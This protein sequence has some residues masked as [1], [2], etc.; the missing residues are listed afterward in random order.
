M[1]LFP[2]FKINKLTNKNS[3]D[4]IYVFYGDNLV[5]DEADI[6]F[7][8][9]PD[10]VIFKSIFDDKELDIIKKDKPKVIF[11]KQSIHIDDSIGVIKLKISEAMSNT[12]SINEMYLFCIKSEYV[13]PIT[14]YQKLTQNDRLSLTRIRFNQFLL[15]LYNEDGIESK[16]IDFNLERKEKYTFDD[17]LKLDFHKH[18]YNIAKAIGQKMIFTDEYPFIADPFYITEYDVLL[19]RSRNEMSSLNNNL[20]LETGKIIK[21]NIYLCLAENVFKV[22]EEIDEEDGSNYA[23]K[24]YFHIQSRIH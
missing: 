11:I 2:I 10:N 21:N 9:E 16:P 4:E 12:V 19:E 24:I 7:Q 8:N 13:N 5:I 18:K 17:I 1:S 6:L 14:V 15:N 23:S 22:L 20:L 3:I